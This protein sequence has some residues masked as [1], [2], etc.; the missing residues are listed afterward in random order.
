MHGIAISYVQ[1]SQAMFEH[2]G[3]CAFLYIEVFFVFELKANAFFFLMIV[4]FWNKVHV[5]NEDSKLKLKWTH[6]YKKK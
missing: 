2:G 1:H 5:H 6:R 3:M 4:F